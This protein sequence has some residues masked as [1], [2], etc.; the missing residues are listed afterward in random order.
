MNYQYR[1]PLPGYK[2]KGATIDFYDTRAAIEAIKPG[3]YVKL[4]Y[5]SRI[6]AEQ[7]VRKCDPAILTDSLKQIIDVKQ[8]L[9]FP[10]Y[11][12]RVV[13]HDILG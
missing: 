12:A 3:S 10:W 1:K 5:T 9:D 7:L 2:N 4:P 13:C 11:P 8:D 6:L